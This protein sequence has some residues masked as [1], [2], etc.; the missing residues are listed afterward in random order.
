MDTPVAI[1]TGA[2]SGMGLSTTV[3]L[4]KQGYHVIMACRSAA[5]G[6]LALQEA[7]SQSKSDRIE[8]M[9]CDLGSILSIHTFAKQFAASYPVLDVL[10]N[11]AGV[12]SVKRTLTTDGFESMMGINHLGHFLLTHLLLGHLK[13]AP[14]GRI[15]TVSSGVH[16]IGR[17]H[18]HDPH[19]T[20]RFN[21]WKGYAQSKLANI[22]FTRELAQRLQG[23]SV[24]ANCLHPGAVGTNIGVDRE[25]GFGKRILTML[26]PFFLTPQ[27]GAETAI[28]LATSPEVAQISGEYFYKK[29][30]API[31]TRAQDRKLGDQLWTWSEQA[32][33]L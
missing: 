27:Q 5:R 10:I 33:G 18:F 29:K 14:Q 7:R 25:T 15:V 31:T 19:L 2:N 4:A 17:I 8:L 13:R 26:R 28:Y 9:L 32:V 11:N 24:T 16:K 3:E 23:T 12:I 30:L 1:V 22:L 21:M 20:Q 6:E